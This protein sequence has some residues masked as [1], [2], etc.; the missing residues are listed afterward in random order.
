[1]RK[2][3]L[4]RALNKLRTARDASNWSGKFTQDIRAATLRHRQTQI[5]EPID[6]VIALLQRA[7]DKA[8]QKR[9][10]PGLRGCAYT[11]YAD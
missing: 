5:A 10:A 9:K 7:L 4:E 11:P 1:M 8:K 3:D 6:E 2:R